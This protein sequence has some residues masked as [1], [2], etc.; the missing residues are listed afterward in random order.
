MRIMKGNA[1]HLYSV[2]PVEPHI[3]NTHYREVCL[4]T[5]CCNLDYVLVPGSFQCAFSF[6][7]L[8]RSVIPLLFRRSTDTD[9]DPKP[10]AEPCRAQT[11]VG[12]ISQVS[13]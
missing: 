6:K 7:P 1:R 3:K 10:H 2:L 9:F 8:L 12:L 4:G 5:F 13:C 11:L